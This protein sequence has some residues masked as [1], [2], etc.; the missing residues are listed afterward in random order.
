MW[1]SVFGPGWGWAV[2]VAMAFLCLVAGVLGFLSIVIGRP[3]REVVEP[4]DR[5]WRRF[6]EGDLTREEFIRL[7]RAGTSRG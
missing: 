2:L 3:P 6:E 7:T 1:P 4:L 5:L